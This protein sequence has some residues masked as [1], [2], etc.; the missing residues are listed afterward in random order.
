MIDSN[1]QW[2]LTKIRNDWQ[3]LRPTAVGKDQVC[4]SEGDK[5]KDPR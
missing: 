1:L 3:N 2:Q 5:V 4:I